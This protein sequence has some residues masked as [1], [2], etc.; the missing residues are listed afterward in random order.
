MLPDR[1]RRVRACLERS[2]A[3]R[4]R[5][6][7]LRRT[8][9]AIAP[10]A[11]IA[12]ERREGCGAVIASSVDDAGTSDA[13]SATRRAVRAR[14]R[15]RRQVRKLRCGGG[16]RIMVSGWHSAIQPRHANRPGR[17]AR[18]EASA[19]AEEPAGS[20]LRAAPQ[21]AQRNFIF[22]TPPARRSARR[23]ADRRRILAS[24]A[25]PPSAHRAAKSP[26]PAAR[27]HGGEQRFQPSR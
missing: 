10:I 26:K 15:D 27:L 5:R 21:R 17:P 14:C 25:G 20:I 2:S 18:S 3:R 11:A 8:A 9:R 23:S 1:Q 7:K 4:W 13:A 16:L 22:L 6:W 12:A 19:P 24:P